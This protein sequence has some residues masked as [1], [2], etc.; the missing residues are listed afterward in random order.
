[1]IVT[2]PSEEGLS[3]GRTII[4]G[5]GFVVLVPVVLPSVA[6]VM[7]VFVVFSPVRLSVLFMSVA[8]QFVIFP[9]EILVL[10][11]LF[12]IIGLLDAEVIT[13]RLTFH[14]LLDSTK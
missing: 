9:S 12:S 4:S 13:I 14:L 2:D 7:F 3:N 6:L 1:M 10:L 11:V 5:V 8:L